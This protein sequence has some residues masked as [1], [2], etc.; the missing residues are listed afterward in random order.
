MG[1]DGIVQ[2]PPLLDEYNCLGQCVEDL[3]VQELVPQL[4]VEAFVVAVL[5]GTAWLDEQRLNANPGQ[6]PPHELGRELWPVVR[7]QMLGR[8]VMSEELGQNLEHVMGSDL[9]G[10]LDRH[11][12]PRVLVE[13]GQQLQGSTVVRSCAH[14]VIGPDVT[15]V[16]RPEPDARTIVEP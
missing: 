9:S 16:Q 14:E 13:H 12:L 7:T 6:P 11:T 10:H 8:A 5:P 4:A 1:S 15:L 3:A 2:P